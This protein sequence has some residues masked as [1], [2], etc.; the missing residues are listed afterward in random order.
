MDTDPSRVVVTEN[1]CHVCSVHTIQVHHQHFP[2]LRF[3]DD[4]AEHAATHLVDRLANADRAVASDSHH[5]EAVQQVIDDIR[6]FL[7]REGSPHPGRDL[8]TQPIQA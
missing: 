5:R 2:E 4:S 7:N 8:Q 6:A 3:V 1:R